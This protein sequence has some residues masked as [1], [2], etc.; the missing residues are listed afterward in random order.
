MARLDQLRG[1]SKTRWAATHHGNTFSRLQVYRT[2]FDE[3]A[4]EC[5]LDDVFFDLLNGYRW[6]IDA[7]YTG[8]LAGGRTNSS[9]KFG[10]IVGRCQYLV[11]ILP[12][13]VIYRV[14]KFGDDIA[15]GAARGADGF[16]AAHA[17]GRLIYYLVR[18]V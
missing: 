15:Q 10:E 12:P 4:L 7:Q 2:C 3:F 6:A 5:D 18:A 14:S 1:S 11:R 13:D 17:P 16:S 8:R 9:R